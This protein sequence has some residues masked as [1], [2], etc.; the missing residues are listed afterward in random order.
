MNH[1]SEQLRPSIDLMV[2]RA[3]DRATQSALET[4]SQD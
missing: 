4:R 3:V 1:I 2:S